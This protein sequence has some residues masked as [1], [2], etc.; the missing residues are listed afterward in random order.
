MSSES[1][2]GPFEVDLDR[3]CS[4]THLAMIANDLTD[5]ELL[6]YGLGLSDVEVEEVDRTYRALSLKRVKMLLKWKNKYKEDATYQRLATAFSLLKRNDMAD[7]VC[8]VSATPSADSGVHYTSKFAQHLKTW[9]TSIDPDPGV[10]PPIKGGK[11]CKLHMQKVEIQTNS[12]EERFDN[13]P[14]TSR[15]RVTIELES[16]FDVSISEKDR[17]RKKV[18]LIEGAPGSGKSTLL[19]HLSEKWASGELFQEF[20]L[21]IYI[22][23]REYNTTQSLRSVADIL[24][25]SSDMKESAWD[26]IKTANGKGVLFLLDGWDE[27]PQSMQTNSIFK[28]IIKS[29]PKYPLLPSTV[30]VT[31]RYV[32]SDDLL[33]L[34]TSHLEILGFT[35]HE[36]NECIL[37]TTSNNDEATHALMAALESRPSLLSSCYL[38]LNVRII[39]YIFQ[40][41]RD[42]L[43]FT[44]LEIYKLLVLNCIQRHVRNKEPDKDHDD[45]ISLETLPQEL[46]ASFHSLCELAFNGLI[47]DKMI[48]TKNELRSIP[49]HLSLLHGAK[50]HEGSGPQMKYAFFHHNIQGLLAAIH[51]SKIPPGDQLDYFQKIFG[52]SRFDVMIQFYAGVTSLQLTGIYGILY[53]TMSMSRKEIKRLNAH[54]CMMFFLSPSALNYINRVYLP[55]MDLRDEQYEIVSSILKPGEN[56]IKK[57]LRSGKIN[58]ENFCELTVGNDL[59]ASVFKVSE[60]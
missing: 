2:I 26:E 54:T 1:E 33:S 52:E 21:V 12:A 50:I 55:T 59:K 46:C 30:V 17:K 44:L 15:N 47:E 22:R 7:R 36:V 41:R 32:S 13:M 34:T 18:I 53:N 27:L 42:N 58:A 38:P 37:D 28:D 8:Q 31:S 39:S 60:Q 57:N 20:H 49:D 16:I 3:T 4:E 29:S 9:Y 51:M 6:A 35:D 45:I 56:E 14:C 23:L 11:F 19:C 43:P 25:C 48:F 40:V 24:P 5:W 10:W